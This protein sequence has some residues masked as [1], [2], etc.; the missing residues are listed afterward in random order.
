MKRFAGS[1]LRRTKSR[2]PAGRSG[3]DPK[4]PSFPESVGIAPARSLRRLPLRSIL[5][6]CS[7]ANGVFTPRD[8]LVEALA[9]TSDPWKY[10]GL[11]KK[12]T[13]I[14]KIQGPSEGC[15]CWRARIWAQGEDGARARLPAKDPPLGGKRAQIIPL[16]FFFFFLKKSTFLLQ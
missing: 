5:G 2:F 14:G 8:W 7:A 3:P 1:G 4:L 16:F 13:K 15:E 9:K 10:Q 12:T 6:G 11:K